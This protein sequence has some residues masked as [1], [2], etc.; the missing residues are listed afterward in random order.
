MRLQAGSITVVASGSDT[1]PSLPHPLKVDIATLHI[2]A[3]QLHAE[4]LADVHAFIT[5]HQS[6]FDGRMQKTDPCAF[7]RSAGDNGIESLPDPRFQQH[8]CRG[9]SDLPFDLL[10][11]VFRFGAVLGERLQFIVLIGQVNFPPSLLSANAV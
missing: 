10:R 2:R 3:D 4:P 8:G 7:V 11:G 9:F 5:A 1:G 6:S